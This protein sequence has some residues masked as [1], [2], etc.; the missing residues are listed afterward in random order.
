MTQL[1]LDAVDILAFLASRNPEG[2]RS[3]VGGAVG[4]SPDGG[5]SVSLAECAAAAAEAGLKESFEARMTE[6]F[7]EHMRFLGRIERTTR[8]RCDMLMSALLGPG[9]EV[10]DGAAA[11]DERALS[12]W[13]TWVE[14]R[15]GQ[16]GQEASALL[17]SWRAFRADLRAAESRWD[18]TYAEEGSR[19]NVLGA[20]A[21][22]VGGRHWD[23]ASS[24][25]PD[26]V[27]VNLPF[28]PFVGVSANDD[29]AVS[30]VIGRAA[31]L[32]RKCKAALFKVE[33]EV[34]AR[35]GLSA[36][37]YEAAIAKAMPRHQVR[38]VLA[39]NARCSP[40]TGPDL[41]VA[42]ASAWSGEFSIVAL[43]R[44]PSDAS[45]P[46]SPADPVLP[47]AERVLR[48]FLRSVELN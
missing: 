45:D 33:W 32:L 21:G 30:E 11:G 6:R 48:G 36:G 8:K 46:P 2:F 1:R 17:S 23:A 38:S 29:P 27:L 22:L 40:A 13:T 19:Q 35:L 18:F 34:A 44:A 42:A 20:A 7:G 12:T 25:H 16:F 41:Y 10:L 47:I 15:E 9:A 3:M 24:A 5:D 14:G 26:V 39:D 43:G 37:G 31:P 28:S 4:V